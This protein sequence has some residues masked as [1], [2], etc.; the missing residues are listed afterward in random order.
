[1]SPDYKS[2]VL[3]TA[4][5]AWSKMN[6]SSLTGGKNLDELPE[7]RYKVLKGVHG[8]AY[9]DHIELNQSDIDD[10][11]ND[12]QELKRFLQRVTIHE[13]A[14]VAEYKIHK[15]MSHGPNWHAFDTVGGGVGLHIGYVL[16]E[17][18]WELNEKDVGPAW[19]MLQLLS[20]CAFSLI[21]LIVIVRIFGCHSKLLGIIITV[22]GF[23]SMIALD[24][25]CVKKSKDLELFAT[26]KFLVVV[27]LAIYLMIKTGLLHF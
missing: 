12:E 24:A 6:D 8:L 2:F 23:F 15:V 20:C 10:L 7:I 5:A 27:P 18:D 19:A 1:M 16:H 14:H 22:F 3:D 21:L 11:A 17:H 26:V 25:V 13:L 9:P 4:N